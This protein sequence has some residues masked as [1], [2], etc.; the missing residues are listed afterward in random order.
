MTRASLPAT[1]GDLPRLAHHSGAVLGAAAVLLVVLLTLSVGTGSTWVS[2]ADVWSAVTGAAAHPTHEHIVVG[3]RLPRALIAAVAGAMLGLAGAVLQSA[4]RNDLADPSLIGVTS[5]AALTVVATLFVTGQGSVPQPWSTVLAFSGGIG[6]CALIWA[7]SWRT[8]PHSTRLVLDGVLVSA[9]LSAL[10]SVLLILDGAL[11]AAVLRWVVGS[12]N[13][14]VW[15]DWAALW[16]VAVV[17][18]PTALALSRPLDSLWMGDPVASSVG[19][20][21]ARA[22]G[23]A[24]VIAT[25]LTA[26]AVSVV[27]AIGFVGLIAPHLARRIVGERP[28]RVLPVAT[29]V[30]ALLLTGADL[31]AQVLSL[32]VPAGEVGGRTALPAGAVTAVLGGP[33]LFLLLARRSR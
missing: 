6:A 26:G 28:S 19:I 7:L 12:L 13:G 27:G 4:T 33:L 32:V 18:I 29:A 11:F 16:P 8:S 9:I 1:R 17:A 21:P 25:L 24:L 10:V 20:R 14:R 22:R 31:F 15:Q 30:G 3:L 2:P 5:G 23:I